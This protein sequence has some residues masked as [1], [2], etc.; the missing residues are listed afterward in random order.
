VRPPVTA[1]PEK[2][3]RASKLRTIRL[4]LAVYLGFAIP[5]VGIANLLE[6]RYGIPHVWFDRLLILLASGALLT[7]MVAWQRSH[8]KTKRHGIGEA[9]AY[10]LL[11]L[12]TAGAIVFLPKSGTPRRAERPSTERSIA[13]LP[14]QNFSETK[15]EYFSDGIT[16][17][18]L[19]Q[20]SKIADLR[21][22]SRTTMMQYKGTSKTLQEIG[23]ELNVGA[24][25]EGSIRRDHSRVRVVGQ[26]IDAQT[27]EHLWAD[28][29]DRELKDVF[30]IQSEIAR[31]I[32][33]ALQAVLSPKEEARISSAPTTNMEAYAL[34]LQGR[35]HYNRY[36]S[37]E[38]EKAMES[39]RRAIALD[40]TFALALAG[41]SDAYSQRVQRY[42]YTLDYLDSAL[43][44]GQHAL[45][46]NPESA[47]AN[48]ALGL[49]Y[50]NLGQTRDAL[51]FYEKAVEINPNYYFAL[52]NLGL[53]NY[54]TGHLDRALEAALKVV[55]LAPDD[56]ISYVQVGLTLQTLEY[57]S[58]AEA[59]YRKARR[60][61]QENPFPLL[62]L[63]WFYLARGDLEASRR[64]AD[65]L[66]ELAPSLPPALDLLLN[67]QVK[68]G[69]Y[70][71]AE[72]T[73]HRTGLE[74]SARG[75]F[76][77]QKLGKERE[78]RAMAEET[79]ERCKRFRA[80]G[81][82]GPST[83]W[84]GAL[85]YLLVGA[86]DSSLKWMSESIAAGWRDYRLAQQDPLLE[87][88]AT[89]RV[90][91]TLMAET[92]NRILQMKARVKAAY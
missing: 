74:G 34:Y 61:D 23:R 12:L 52:R 25:L 27:D 9:L 79:I 4:A 53:L 66:V 45:A 63:G 35:Q 73:F 84:E 39:F 21:V 60:L 69:A 87:P 81:D 72:K 17:D 7:A 6:G 62:G 88:I 16:E 42:G 76:L 32:A 30:A 41:L 91:Q 65:T 8:L 1:V 59:W 51:E 26:L 58:A 37:S 14:F 82:E 54:R 92:R 13:V 44:A 11:T 46:L 56:M 10:L 2:H 24:I 18:I 48:K 55:S 85:A 78:G 77:L 28:T 40:S 36:T 68:S 64:A 3:R 89:E 71:A 43:Q 83:L 50:D 20:L 80:R 29:Y 33:R 22:I 47:E 90:F 31:E 49:V 67:L 38:N 75:A 86:K 5:A 57:D 15:D 70:R 19:T